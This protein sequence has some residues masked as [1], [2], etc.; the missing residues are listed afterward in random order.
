LISR[1]GRFGGAEQTLRHP[2]RELT[3]KRPAPSAALAAAA[4]ASAGLLSACAVPTPAGPSF[5]AMPGAGKTLDQ[6]QADDQKCRSYA[7]Q[8]NGNVSPAQGATQ[9]AVGSAAIGTA[10]GAA[11][12]A[13]IGA[14]G[15]AAGAGA[16]VGASNAQL[17]A[18]ALQRNYDNAYAQCMAVAGDKLPAPGPPVAVAYPYPYPYPY[19]VYPPV[20]VGGVGFV[21]GYRPYYWRRW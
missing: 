18:G 14:A 16:A 12:G 8:A 21:Y 17:S 5:A 19:G 11:A 10:L 2:A 4:L 7:N 3:M 20:V 15:G 9:S 6:F 1:R 13:L